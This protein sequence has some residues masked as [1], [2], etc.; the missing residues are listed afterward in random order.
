M[1]R[2]FRPVPI[3]ALRHYL[4]YDPET[5]VFSRLSDRKRV[6]FLDGNGYEELYVAGMRYK[7]HR[8]AYA[9]VHGD[10]PPHLDIDHIDGCRTNNRASNLRATNRSQNCQNQHRP[11]KDGAVGVRGVYWHK[12][13][14]KY[15]AQ[16][17][18][19]GKNHH[20]GL[21]SDVSSAE[22]ARKTA[23]MRLHTHSPHNTDL[24]AIPQA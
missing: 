1:P 13:T 16:I 7:A 6:G 23:E 17:M 8:V 4:A 3:E 22:Q 12:K 5:G 24:L 9:F 19:N 21:F 10:C 11:H 2:A 18:L 14:G 20:L 15:A